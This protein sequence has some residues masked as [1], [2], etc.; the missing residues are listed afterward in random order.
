M[1]QRVYVFINS[2]RPVDKHLFP[3]ETFL[4]CSTHYDTIINFL[5]KCHEGGMDIFL[6]IDKRVACSS[7][8]L[9]YVSSNS[10][11]LA[12]HIIRFEL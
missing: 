11:P 10:I 9:T 3:N 12:G 4:F 2:R 1:A 7:D 5:K 6:D 8:V